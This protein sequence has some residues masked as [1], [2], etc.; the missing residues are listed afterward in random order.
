MRRALRRL[1]RVFVARVPALGQNHAVIVSRVGYCYHHE[2]CI[3]SVLRVSQTTLVT[4]MLMT[5]TRNCAYDP[6]LFVRGVSNFERIFLELPALLVSLRSL[7]VGS[8]M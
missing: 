3:A 2:Q 5:A 8:L 1:T 6:G 4:L 7:L